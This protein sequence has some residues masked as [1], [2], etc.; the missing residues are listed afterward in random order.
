MQ[1]TRSKGVL[2]HGIALALLIGGA[3]RCN[4]QPADVQISGTLQQ[5]HK[6]TVEL[7]GLE[8]SESASDPN[9]FTQLEMWVQFRHPASQL[10]YRVPGYF[11]A[12]GEAAKSGAGEGNAWRAHLAPDAAGRWEYEIE[13]YQG[14]TVVSGNAD[15]ARPLSP[16]HGLSGSFQIEP[17]TKDAPGFRAE[18]RLTVTDSGYLRHAGSGRYF[19][20]AG[21]DAPETLLAYRD[22]DGITTG[23]PQRAPLKDW[24]PHVK[25]WRE[26][27]PSWR[28]GRGRGLIGAINYIA[29]QGCNSISFLPYN[30][31]GDGDNVWPFVSRNDKLHYD[32]SKLDQWQIVF[33]H[34]TERGVH[35]HFK[36]QETEIDDERRGHGGTA[37]SVPEALDGGQLGVERRLYI[38]ELVARF[39]HALGLTWNI[40]EE[41]TQSAEEVR[42]MIDFIDAMDPYDHLIVIH[43]FPGEQDKVYSRLLPPRSQ[44]TGASLQ[45]P[46]H[47]AHRRTLHWVRRSREAGRRWIVCNDEQNPA[48]DGVPPDPG[49]QGHD[50]I[51]ARDSDRPY[52]L[53]DIRRYTLWGTLLAGGAGVEY[54]FGYQLPQNDLNCQDFRSRQRSWKYCRIALQ[55]FHKHDIPFWQMDCRDALVG[56]KQHENTRYC[57]ARVGEVYLVYLTTGGTSSLDLGDSEGSFEVRWFD[58]RGGG[59]LQRGSVATIDGGGVRELGTPP[60][61]VNEDWLVLVRRPAAEPRDR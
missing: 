19:L 13:F 33:D 32:C 1:I 52:D 24:Q 36:L 42:A 14:G 57:F 2:A 56:N 31:G 26:G 53:H 12:D 46:W 45:N 39:G 10:A 28:E 18:G 27:D 16:W 30:A 40:G 48:S 38:R 3:A 55:F 8:A 4:A 60:S 15:E 6:V 51:A 47:A 50:G 22:F 41:N 49:Y 5:W 43:T 34:A 11:A 58:P 37:G 25:D 54:Y 44:L 59:A 61:D 29:S 20:K 17:S 35:L 23:N 9:P 21:P 7:A